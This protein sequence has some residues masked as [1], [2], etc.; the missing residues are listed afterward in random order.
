MRLSKGCSVSRPGNKGG[1]VCRRA[2][3]NVDLDTFG[4]DVGHWIGVGQAAARPSSISNPAAGGSDDELRT[5]QQKTRKR[6]ANEPHET[7]RTPDRMT[8]VR[9]SQRSVPTS[10][11]ETPRFQIIIFSEF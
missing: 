1:H 6:L 3:I 5:R 2:P 11:S 10:K 4:P 7:L 9:A 8:G